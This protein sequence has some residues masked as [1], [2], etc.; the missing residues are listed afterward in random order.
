LAGKKERLD[1]LT[2]E[3]GLFPSRE[4]AKRAIMAGV[5]FVDGKMVDKGGTRVAEHSKIVVKE[6]PVPY[7]GRGGL[8]LEKAL[9][10]FKVDVSGK[11]AV[12]VGAST[13]GF[14]DCL[15][16]KGTEKVYAIDVGYGQLDWKLR[17]DPRVVT[18][19]RT[20]IRYVKP[21]DIGE[22]CHIAVIDVAFI[23]LTLVLPVVNNLLTHDGEIVAL[24]KPQFE[25]GREKVGKKGIVRD[26]GVHRE[27]VERIARFIQ[28]MGLSVK[29]ITYSPVTGADGNIE[30]LA[31]ASKVEGGFKSLKDLK[32]TVQRVVEDAH[33]TLK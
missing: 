30:Y 10:Y 23:S 26:P 19:E 1:V 16:Q 6:D 11:R 24:I 29:G 7:V 13:G 12:D 20:N 28:G 18:M 3:K 17:K 22:L 27:V 21:E 32:D 25:A 5:V 15:L 9:E 4:R 31:Y 14:T 8:K 33:N 2:V